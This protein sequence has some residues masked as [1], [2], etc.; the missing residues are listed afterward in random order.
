[1][2]RRAL[3]LRCPVCGA[4]GIWRSFGQF[5]ERCPGC[6][7]RFEREEGCVRACAVAAACPEGMES[8]IECAPVPR[9]AAGPIA[10][11]VVSGER[12]QTG[13]R[14]ADVT[15]G[16]QSGLLGDFAHQ[17]GQSLSE[18]VALR[19]YE[20]QPVPSPSR[21]SR[22]GS[23]PVTRTGCPMSPQSRSGGYAGMHGV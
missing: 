5:V 7:Y 11:G 18:A 14:R 17:M 12:P 1:M 6:G 21:S 8:L 16:Q 19:R 23:L 3:R 13:Q 20:S 15:T 2:I 10:T 4:G 9:G 22:C